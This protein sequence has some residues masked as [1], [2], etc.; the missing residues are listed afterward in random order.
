MAQV[1]QAHI[2]TAFWK[3]VLVR[4]VAAWLSPGM[5]VCAVAVWALWQVGATVR[6]NRANVLHVSASA[7]TGVDDVFS[8]SRDVTIALL[9]PCK[10]NRPD[11][12]GLVPGIGAVA[13]QGAEQVE[14]SGTLIQATTRNLDA[15]GVAVTGTMGHLNTASDDIAGVAR[16][17]NSS[18]TT[19]STHT[20]TAIDTANSTL[21]TLDTAIAT[22]NAAFSKSQADFQAVLAGALPVEAKATSIA[23]HWDGISGDFQTRFHLVLFPKPCLTFGCKLARA[24]PYIKDAA[25]LGESAYWTRALFEN[26]KP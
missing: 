24:Y 9:K 18:L 23:G 26:I 8:E 6:E 5:I 20:Q 12:C 10:P 2:M 22:Q 1:L 19:L 15:V 14:Q 11:T 21:G 7:K 3:R 13:A 4:A 16:T 25:T 17:A